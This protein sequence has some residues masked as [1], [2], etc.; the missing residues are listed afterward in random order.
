M[1]YNFRY[2]TSLYITFTTSAGIFYMAD[3]SG[4]FGQEAA[5]AKYKTQK[6]N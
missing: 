3:S 4:I 6:S 2:L 1:Q 5:E